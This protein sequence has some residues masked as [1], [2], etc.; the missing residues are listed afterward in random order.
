MARPSICSVISPSAAPS[1]WSNTA[2][3]LDARCVEL[4]HLDR[5]EGRVVHVLL[6][7]QLGIARGGIAFFLAAVLDVFAARVG[8]RDVLIHNAGVTPLKPF[9]RRL[10]RLLVAEVRRIEP[11]LLIT[12]PVVLIAHARDPR[13]GVGIDLAVTQYA[14]FLADGVASQ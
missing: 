2:P 11:E 9:A 13:A 4:R 12:L 5:A 14:A 10:V 3:L 8:C 7:A 1:C 6:E